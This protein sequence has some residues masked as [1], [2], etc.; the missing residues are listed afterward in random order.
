MRRRDPLITEVADAMLSDAF[1]DAICFDELLG[2]ICVCGE[3]PWEEGK[4]GIMRPW[5]PTDDSAGYA[6][7][8]E[9]FDCGIERDFQH[10]LTIAASKRQ[11]NP[12]INLLDAL[13]EWDGTRR[14]GTLMQTF[15]GAASDD[16]MSEVERLL[17]GAALARA[18]DPGC[19]FD[20]MPVLIGHQ[21][22]GKSTFI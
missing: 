9:A 22:I 17:M 5:A 3:L 8:Q 10:A 20:Y 14:V 21:G 16:Y 18:F 1:R 15:L 12:I 4:Q 6:Y 13:P 7:P 19:K 2:R 11:V